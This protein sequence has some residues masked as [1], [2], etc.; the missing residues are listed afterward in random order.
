MAAGATCVLDTAHRAGAGF[1]RAWQ[2]YAD[3]PSNTGLLHY[4]A[5]LE[6]VH[7]PSADAANVSSEP[8]H[9][10]TKALSAL[11][12]AGPPAPGFYRL[13]FDQGRVLLTLCIGPRAASLAQLVMQLH[14]Y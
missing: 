7:W 14:V 13:P 3:A 1:L 11:D 6:T 10:L 12:V 2:A 5:L 8:A 4:V 9:R